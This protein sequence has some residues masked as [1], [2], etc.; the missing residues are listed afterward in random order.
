MYRCKGL[1]SL[2]RLGSPG[3][4]GIMGI[5]GITRVKDYMM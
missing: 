1:L 2:Q 3:L 5:S 4:L